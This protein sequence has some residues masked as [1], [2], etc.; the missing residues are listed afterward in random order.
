MASLPA[1]FATGGVKTIHIESYMVGAE[2]AAA[3]FSVDLQG[4]PQNCPWKLA[5]EELAFLTQEVKFLCD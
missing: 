2:L 5:M 4:H 3:M 1:G